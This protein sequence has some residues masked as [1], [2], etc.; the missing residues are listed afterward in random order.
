MRRTLRVGVLLHEK[1]YFSL[2][3]IAIEN[4]LLKNIRVSVVV[5]PPFHIMMTAFFFAIH[6]FSL[7]FFHQQPR[8]DGAQVR[9]HIAK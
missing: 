5:M 4:P 3:S 8:V 9:R 1:H 2:Y 6:S 7:L